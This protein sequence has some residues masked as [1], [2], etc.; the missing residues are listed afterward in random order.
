MINKSLT[1]LDNSI[2]I[3][4]FCFHDL[5]LAMLRN[6]KEKLCEFGDF[7]VPLVHNNHENI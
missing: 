3:T 7:I 2:S 1:Y 6:P 5:K 4:E